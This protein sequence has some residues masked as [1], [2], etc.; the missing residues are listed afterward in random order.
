MSRRRSKKIHILI[1]NDL[2]KDHFIRFFVHRILKNGKK[3]LA[4]RIVYNSLQMIEKRTRHNP[5][6]ILT[7]AVN[8][9][10][11]N[12]SVKSKRKSGATYQIPIEL[13]AEQGAN[14][15]IRWILNS[16]KK[17]SGKNMV[18]QFSSELIDTARQTGQS[19]RKRDETHRMAEANRVF[20]HYR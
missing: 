3:F 14:L 9:A 11:P 16:S 10:S 15:A 1:K 13:T 7:Q 12:V 19:L 18:W 4:F 2:Y 17:R 8:L 6:L 20:A 5:L